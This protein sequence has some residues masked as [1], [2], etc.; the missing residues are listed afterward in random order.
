M[1]LKLT[2]DAER[3]R[4]LAKRCVPEGQALEIDGLLRALFH[5]SSLSVRLPKLASVLSPPKELRKETP[6]AVP[7][8]PELKPVFAELA[9]RAQEPLSPEAWFS[10]LLESEPGQAYAKAV[11]IPPDALAGL[12]GGVK[13][14]IGA[15]DAG[16]TRPTNG[17]RESADR[18]E[19]VE[20]LATYGRMLTL[21]D[22]PQKNVVELDKP[23]RSLF[24][25]LI[26]RKQRSAMVIGL[27]GTGKSALVYEFA[28][29]L[30]RNDLSVPEKIRDHDVFELS[31]VFLRS[32]ASLVGEY[33][34]RVSAL[35]RILAAHP[36][37][38]LFVDEAHSMFQS[39]IHQ[40]GPFSDANEAFKQAI[41]SGDL[42]LIGCTT[43][44]EYRHFIE[45]DQA[46]AQRFT[47]VTVE[48][49]SKAKTREIMLARR[50]GVEDFYRV[51]I[52]DALLHRIVDL[53]EEYLPARAQPR[54]SIQLLDEACSYCLIQDP[55][56]SELSEKEVW[57]ALEDTIGHSVI[58]EDALTEDTVLAR[59]KGKIVGQDE[60]LSG[61]A[62]AFV[63]GMGG[64]V[65][66][67]DNP[68]GVFLFSG[69]TGVGKTET[70]LLLSEILGG[71]SESLLRV[72]CNTLQGDG[73]DG[74]PAQ[75]VLFGPPPGYLG[76]VRGQGG[77]LNRIRD[78]PECIVLFD[79][80]EKAD[81]SVGEL[82]F[83]IIDDGT[84]EDM[85]GNRLDFR[86]SFIVFTTNAGAV[87]DQQTA[88]GFAGQKT[89]PPSEPTTDRS[90]LEVHFAG[91]GLGQA[92]L[93]RISHS[94]D[95]KGLKPDA[96]R[97][98]LASQ[99][100]G[101]AEVAE[102]RGYDLE[103]EETVLD[104]LVSQWQPRFGVRHLVA[105]LRNRVVEQLSVADAQGELSGVETI[106]LEVMEAGRRESLG[107]MS[108]VAIR[109]R[110]ENTLVISLA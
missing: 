49:P 46:L 104:H 30:V 51:R 64:W 55:P 52:P 33:E 101:L 85:E 94:F 92:F 26:K 36:K 87:Y 45:P 4:D 35:L 91:M 71:G 28:R 40:R 82:L 66:G 68:R 89:G 39:G 99:L 12:E 48:A 7:L 59:L 50:G 100:Q 34:K 79:E 84:C 98:I 110:D 1:A 57:Q 17:W 108:G 13:E 41:M 31:P 107:E 29:R 6:A 93:G 56:V 18:K 60:V 32:G 86:R 77:V 20:A 95:F 5:S 96:V 53:T 76:Y 70:A 3:A 9:S 11:G 74:G 24:R 97:I 42:S 102:N 106:R 62:K 72:D 23:L 44:A 14:E 25:A 43:T 90:A 67:A 75:N 15:E 69:P 80:I 61:I 47:T 27:P 105:I 8:G 2:P 22:P 37:V 10:A 83:R 73:R 19:V 81:P 65:K 54:K 109:E 78:N 103:W 63:A 21:G 16:E 38:I 58:R 88:I